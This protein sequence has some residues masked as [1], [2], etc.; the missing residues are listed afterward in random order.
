MDSAEF[1]KELRL[2]VSHER[3]DRYEQRGIS[4]GDSNL[5][6]HYAWNIA[7]AESLYP[8]LQFLEVVLRNSVHDA[9]SN[10]YGTPLWWDQANFLN[11]WG[12]N[13]VARVKASIQKDKKT[14]TEGRIVAELTFGFW[15]A[16]FA[17]RYE[18]KV[19]NKIN[20]KVFLGLKKHER[21]RGRFQGKLNRL[22]QLRNKVFHHEPIWHFR[23]LGT[24]HQEV[25]WLIQL[26]RP[27][28]VDYVKAI[29]RFPGLYGRG[30]ATFQ[31][32]LELALPYIAVKPTE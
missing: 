32:E 1:F 6:V 7:L 28:I 3:L 8:S 31:A 13:E 24:D 20:K 4:G 19:W 25:L 12:L 10:A 23:T 29:D 2:A 21:V 16:L 26:M 22:R 30:M 11:A 15:T 18:P 5:T 9:L 14:I 17:P 27:G